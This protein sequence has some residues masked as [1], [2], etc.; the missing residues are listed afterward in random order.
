MNKINVLFFAEAKV[1]TKTESKTYEVKEGTTVRQLLA[2]I[3]V[4]FPNLE[5][6]FNRALVALN[7]NYLESK[8]DP[9]LKN[10]DELAVIP[11]LSGG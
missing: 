11:P 1:R 10:N 4:E 7:Q 6:V 9:E 2:A 5:T 8:E 3:L